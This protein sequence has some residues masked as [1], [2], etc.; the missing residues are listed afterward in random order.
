MTDGNTPF[1]SI[2]IKEESDTAATLTLTCTPDQMKELLGPQSPYA[3]D[4]VWDRHLTFDKSKRYITLD[5]PN[6]A[7]PGKRATD[8]FVI[9]GD[10]RVE[11]WRVGED[12]EGTVKRR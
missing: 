3:D 10:G 8:H 4:S 12:A 9:H 2:V 1:K 6:P 5:E 7:V 11:L